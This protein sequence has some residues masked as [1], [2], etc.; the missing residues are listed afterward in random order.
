MGLF[1]KLRQGLQKTH[2]K[3]VHELKR[4]ATLSP[5]LTGSTLEELEAALLGA[6][7]GVAVT[8]QILAAVKQSYETQGRGG[9]R[10][11]ELVAQ[12]FFVSLAPDGFG[13]GI[14]AGPGVLRGRGGVQD[15]EQTKRSDGCFTHGRFSFSTR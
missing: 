4:I 13:G 6:D 8:N 1:Q 15:E 5:K 9:L 2:V 14:F 12:L 10:L 11:F 7:L 3:L